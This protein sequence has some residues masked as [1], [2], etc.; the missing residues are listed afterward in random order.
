[1]NLGA[2][3]LGLIRS[4]SVF[5]RA[6]TRLRGAQVAPDVTITGR[7]QLR[8]ARGSRVILSK[9][10]SLCAQPQLNPLIHRSRTTLWAMGP[11]AMIELGDG[12]GCSGICICAAKAVRV[13]EGTIFGA[14]C[15]VVDNDFHLPG[16]AWSWLDRPLETSKPVIIGR[17]CF[18]GARSIILKGVTI[19]DGAVVGAGSVVTRDIPPYHLAGGNPASARPLPDRW[20]RSQPFESASDS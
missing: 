12:V 2:I 4:Q 19:G 14:D 3:K 9:G 13:G 20:I 5:W 6:W 1:M 16:A 10:V 7:L 15:L 8:M 17:G 11:G 18:I